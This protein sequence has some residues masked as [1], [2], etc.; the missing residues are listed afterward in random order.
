MKVEVT[1][2][3]SSKDNTVQAQASPVVLDSSIVPSVDASTQQASTSVTIEVA[4]TTAITA[5]TT[6]DKKP[7]EDE[8]KVEVTLPESSK[9]NTVQV[10]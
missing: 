3:E 9:D 6:T 5:S 4:H 8:M 7:S 1:L 10:Q 2:P